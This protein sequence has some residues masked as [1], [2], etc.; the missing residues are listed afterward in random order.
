M[1][2]K[3]VLLHQ[4]LLRPRASDG[5]TECRAEEIDKQKVYILLRQQANLSSKACSA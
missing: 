1:G 2:K 4:A 5:T 3:S